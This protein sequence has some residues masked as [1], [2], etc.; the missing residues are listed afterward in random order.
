MEKM[1]TGEIRRI[2]FLISEME[3]LYHQADLRLGISDSASLVLYA[4]YDAGGQCPLADIYK[5][6][7]ISKQTLNSGLRT[8]EARG[9]LRLEQHNGR[10][11]RVVLTEAGQEFAQRTVARL[12]QAEMDALNGWTEAEVRAYVEL[13]EKYAVCFRQQIEKL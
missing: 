4:L 7:G 9:L 2:N 5:N 6:S 1:Y 3:S 12:F 11:K 13:Q 8:L 10:S